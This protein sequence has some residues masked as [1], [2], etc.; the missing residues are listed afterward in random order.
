M[1][2]LKPYCIGD[3]QEKI[4]QAVM[5]S[6]SH[7]E[8]AEKLGISRPRVSKVI[9]SIKERAGELVAPTVAREHLVIPDTQIKPGCPMEFMTWIGHYIVEKKPDVVVHIGDHWDFQSLSSYDAGKKSAEGR[10]VIQ[11][12]EAGCLAMDMLLEPIRSYNAS[13]TRKYQP[14]MHFTAGNHEN[15]VDRAAECDAK[16]DGLLPNIPMTVESFGFRYHEFKRPVTIDGVTYCHFFYNPMTGQPYSGMMETR[17]KNVGFS[18]TMG[19]QQGLKTGM[20]ELGNGDIQRGLV[21]GS[22]YLADED[23][24]GHQANG[25][26]RGIIYKHEVFNGNY[27]LMEVSLDFLCRKYEGVPVTEFM[28]R[29]YPDIFA[30]SQ[31]LQ[32]LA[33]RRE[34]K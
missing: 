33:M 16:L 10:R 17:L 14:E 32:R 29:K 23:Y 5:E 3:N 20:R 9:K 18:F 13:R 24:K 2:H 30:Q 25:H 27:D 6:S 19:H 11:D 31:W 7:R 34:G 4:L 26:W 28:R 21:C 12:H 8:A 15:R 1:E 22:S